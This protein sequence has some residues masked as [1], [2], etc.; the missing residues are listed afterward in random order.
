MSHICNK[1][2]KDFKYLSH[3]QRHQ[4]NKKDCLKKNKS[5]I[6]NQIQYNDLSITTPHIHK[7]TEILND[8][9][10]ID[11]QHT[12]T[13]I[14]IIKNIN[15][16]SIQQNN[17]NKN[18][19]PG[20]NYKFYDK[21]GLHKHNKHNRCKGIKQ[22]QQN[23][24]IN[25]T[26]EPINNDNHIDNS[27][28]ITNNITNNDN[29]TINNTNYIININPFK[30]ESLDHITLED[31]K[32]IYETIKGIDAKLF[33]FIYEKNK[34]NINFYKDNINN[35][36]LAYLDH[37]MEIQY[38]HEKQFID[39]LICN[40]NKSKIQLFYLFKDNLS[41]DEIVNYLKNMINYHKLHDN[42][43]QIQQRLVEYIKT[44]LISVYRNKY[45][46]EIIKNISKE[47]EKNPELKQL[48]YQQNKDTI[49]NKT[50]AIKEYNN[51]PIQNTDEKNLY[52]LF[53]RAKSEII[54]SL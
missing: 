53:D 5:D 2:H 41:A 13:I 29:R 30:C 14:N 51:K 54:Q 42:D 20:C 1:C 52:L 34:K 19:C 26:N 11:K 48:L 7:I 46:N 49:H 36:T 24:L 12:K 16:Q 33:H 23:I 44:I 45:N 22:V 39:D 37:H 31:F 15:E 18:V 9:P 4:L 28:N 43:T 47:L 8:M 17:D 21:Q 32:T 38:I 10:Y 6:D 35:N 25:T 50:L 40:L 27:I 3:L